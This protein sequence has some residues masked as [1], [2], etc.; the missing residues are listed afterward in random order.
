MKS[1]AR[2][3]KIIKE[4]RLNNNLR[5]D[6]V[7]KEIGITR[8]TLWAIENGTGNYSI[9]TLLKLV[10]Y[11]NLSIEMES[12]KYRVHKQRAT[13]LNKMIDKKINRFV[14]MCVEQ[15]ALKINKGSQYTY[16]ILDN[17]GIIKELIDDYEDMHGMSTYSINE[18]IDKRLSLED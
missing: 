5:M 14:V 12:S 9:D 1:K 15:Y 7:A 16:R 13:R 2:I 6:D 17:K 10:N 4:S 11:F 8:S 18:Y 3:G